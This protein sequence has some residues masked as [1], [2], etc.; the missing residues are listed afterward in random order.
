[1]K[2]ALKP[3]INCLLFIWQL[4]VH[5]LRTKVFIWNRSNE[6]VHVVLIKHFLWL[7]DFKVNSEDTD[8]HI[9]L[10]DQRFW[11]VWVISAGQKA[12]NKSLNLDNMP[13]VNPLLDQN[14]LLVNWWII[15]SLDWSGTLIWVDLWVSAWLWWL[16]WWWWY[17]WG[18]WYIDWMNWVVFVGWLRR[19]KCLSWLVG[20]GRLVRGF[21]RFWLS[22]VRGWWVS[23]IIFIDAHCFFSYSNYFFFDFDIEFFAWFLLVFNCRVKY[24]FISFLIFDYLNVLITKLDRHI[25]EASFNVVFLLVFKQFDDLAA[26]FSF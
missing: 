1:M 19:I 3:I 15:H 5:S 22:I 9:L 4:N 26:L 7:V 18:C 17:G 23:W 16:C 20:W 24:E 21:D 25:T 10:Q 6:V 13:H 12:S 14:R 2:V 8:L 11:L